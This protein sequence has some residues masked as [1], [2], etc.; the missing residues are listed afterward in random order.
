MEKQPISSKSWLAS[1]Q[2]ALK[3]LQPSDRPIRIA[4]VGVGNELNGDDMAG[5]V[6]ARQ[7]SQ[8]AEGKDNLLVV[9]AGPAPENISGYLRRFGPDLVVMVDAAQM[10]EPPGAVGWLRWQDTAGLS[11]STHTLPL[12][13]FATY[14]T[15]ELGCEMALIGIQPAH[16]AVDGPLSPEVGEAIRATIEELTRVFASIT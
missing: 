3:N 6:L 14:L 11:A 10:S 13:M 2:E 16:N 5:I 8:L 15:A 9:D 12:H 7:L 1:L 4:V